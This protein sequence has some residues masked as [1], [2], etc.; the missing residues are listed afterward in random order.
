MPGVLIVEAM[1]QT[2]GLLILEQV[3]DPTQYA[4]YFLKI[5]KVKF[6]RKV[7]PGDTLI[8]H[9]QLIEPVRRGIVVMQ[10]H[11]YVGNT[12]VAEGTLTAQIAKKQ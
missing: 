2:G 8:M 3:D 11:A 9:L 12:L 1:A 4:S 6:K 5:D 10:G 7:V